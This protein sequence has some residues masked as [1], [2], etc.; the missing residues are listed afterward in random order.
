MTLKSRIADIMAQINQAAL[1]CGRNP[2]D[3]RLVA[4]S[5]TFP[6]EAIEKAVGAGLTVFGENYVQEARPK[7]ERLASARLSW[8][9][10]GHLQTNKAR[11]AVHL[12][13]LIHSVDSLRLAR[14]L[15]REAAK[16]GKIQ[17][18]LI[19]VNIAREAAKS[20]IEPED[21]PQLVDD[22]SRLKHLSLRG[23][24]TMPP[25]F[26]QPEKV[27]P[28]FS[29]LRDLRDRIVAEASPAGISLPE[30]SMGMSGDFAAA[31][32]CG[33]TLIR[34]GTAIFGERH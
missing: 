23:M 5:K 29:A 33:A 25:Y 17:A 26:D 6:V 7:I 9:F 31:I 14:A 28:Y 22:I 18:V 12:F 3:V 8:H 27:R 2:E 19:Q 16:A 4:V 24:M 20:G 21:A 11:Y 15:D 34:I 1:R 32:E 10:I 13:D 30:L